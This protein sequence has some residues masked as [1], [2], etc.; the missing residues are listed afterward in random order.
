MISLT[1]LH[2]R[3]TPGRTVVFE[4][5]CGLDRV[6][7]GPAELLR[8]LETQ[9][10]LPQPDVHRAARVMQ[11][12]DALDKVAEPCFAQSFAADRWETASDLL[13]RRD[14]L[15]ISGWDGKKHDGCPRIAMDL[16]SAET[17]YP[18]SF[19]GE[20]E[21]LTEVLKAL[22]AG[23]QLPEHQLFLADGVESWP[24]V[25]QGVLRRMSLCKIEHQVP[26]GTDGPAL[27][28]A[29]D[30]VRGFATPPF[31]C[32]ASLRV[33]NAR[34]ETAAIEFL[35]SVFSK[36]PEGL[37]RTVV[38]CEDDALAVRLDVCLQRIGLPT[39]GASLQTPAH[40]VLQ[41]LPLALELCWEPVD[42]QCLLDFL[43]LPIIPI[44][45]AAASDLARAL[46]EEPGLGSSSWEKVFHELCE[47]SVQ[48]QEDPG[49]L[50]QRLYDWFCDER[51]P[52]GQS[53]ATALVAKQCRKVAKWAIGR[54]SLIWKD[55]D[56]DTNE[57][58]S[59]EEQIAIALR[60]AARQ[61]SLLGDLVELAGKLE[62]NTITQPQLGRLMEEVMDRGVESKPCQASIGGPA[63]VRSL[64]EID[65]DYDR[66]IWL[67]TN[68]SDLASG[69][70]SVKQ[71]REFKQAGV[72]IDDGSAL[73][74]SLRAAEARGL[75]HA[76]ESMLV[77][78]FP[79]NEEQREHPIWLAIA[80]KIKE[81]HN[82]N[83][84]RADAIEDLIIESRCEAL[85]PFNFSCESVAVRPPQPMRAEWNIPASLLRDRNT[86]SASELE[87]RLACPLK[88][89]LRYQAG[90]RPSEIASLPDE[91]RLRGNLFHKIL[92]Q[93]FGN[94]GDLPS[95]DEAIRLVGE[96]F[97]ERLPLD[98]A[99]LAQPE[100]RVESLKLRSELVK[101]TELFVTTLTAGG[102]QS[103]KIEEPT[104]GSVFGKELEG[105]ID[106]LAKANDDRE[107]VVDFKYAG[108]KKYYK[109]IEEGRSAQLATYAFSRRQV[110]GRFPAVA[111]LI[112]S[113]GTIFT[114]RG[115]PLEGV[116]PAQTI[117]GP[118]IEQV[119]NNFSRAISAADS[120]LTTDEPVPARPLQDA[121]D[122]P[123]GADLVLIDPLPQN[124][125]QSAC[126][127]CDFTRLCGLEETR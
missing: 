7:G 49:K 44:P 35:A 96:A 95:V 82:C 68:T 109:M 22:D 73:L 127:Y 106:C 11:Y 124:E 65:D 61:A 13:A 3:L 17:A 33:A 48:A 58:D 57:L 29:A 123:P 102:Y 37:A 30:L 111:Y 34:S 8:W 76:N 14:E 89:T 15:M 63:R 110:T 9:L 59:S 92:E 6:V 112:L 80:G 42:P 36:A 72:E 103:V 90:L 77:I 114:P 84:W 4:D 71:R 105:S 23:Q 31:D 91:F 46:G 104:E 56:Q 126:R 25:W 43:T 87:D 81:F 116:D 1:Q 101:A 50:K 70:W 39:M 85:T 69:K 62:N 53:V 98:A 55:T 67:G 28:R 51:S 83:E 2:I 119:W 107:A 64:A 74:R 120:W 88:W 113:D 121:A 27:Y 10:G 118:S 108:R 100:K 52:Q 45:R 93:V 26:K 125:T 12:A 99:P 86:A 66:L 24:A 117:N 47:Q 54:A 16:A 40:P 122:W 97:D 78:R 32:D 19:P 94:G 60:E 79:Q 20:C 21:R 41:V 75:S 18:H 115:A 38:Y 5:H